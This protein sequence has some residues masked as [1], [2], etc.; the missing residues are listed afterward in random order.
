[1]SKE[2]KKQKPVNMLETLKPNESSLMTMIDYAKPRLMKRASESL[3]HA[4]PEKQTQFL[5]RTV[6]SI[7]K[8]EKL[9]P[10]FASHEGRVSIYML[11][12]DALKTGLELEKHAYAVPY[13]R[14]IGKGQNQVWITEAKFQIKRQGYHAL[15]C[16]GTK[17]IFED[18]RWGTVYEKDKVSLNRATGE[19]KHHAFIGER[20][21]HIGCWVQ[22]I[23]L[24]GQKE[25]EFYPLSYIN[26]IR[27]KHSKTYQK[28]ID[29]KVSSCAWITD[30]VPMGEKTAIKA[31]CSP[32]ADVKDELANAL[33]SERDEGFAEP[34]AERDNE[35]LADGII[36]EALGNMG[37][38]NTYSRNVSEEDSPDSDNTDSQNANNNTDTANKDGKKGTGVPK[39]SPKS[40]SKKDEK[41][42][43]I[44][45]GNE[46]DLF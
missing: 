24:N 33:Y 19:V 46:R 16:G 40:G 37:E 41:K 27:D 17:P 9:A 26:N 39:K 12:D 43:S 14:S 6:A 45:D 36:D 32:Y 3:Q 42:G 31:F 38:G 35:S 22:V 25:S 7:V 20:G 4:T 44:K 21:K 8:N 23:K 18:L 11:I 13:P 34:G 1:M 30:P 2:T 15:L 29:N 28:Y 10:C 5:S